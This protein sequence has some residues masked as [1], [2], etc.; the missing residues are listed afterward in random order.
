[1]LQLRHRN[2]F[3]RPAQNSE[4]LSRDDHQALARLAAPA[5]PAMSEALTRH[6][7]PADNSCLFTACAYLC[8]GLT[9]DIEL[10]VAGRALRPVCALVRWA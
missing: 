5:K 3:L 6:K 2:G 4:S 8:Q 10:K 7:V 1:M 9:G